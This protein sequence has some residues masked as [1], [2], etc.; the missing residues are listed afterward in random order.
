MTHI[1]VLKKEVLFYLNPKTN[2]NFVDCTFGE[3]GH[4]FAI[5]EKNIPEGKIL[6]IDRSPEIIKRV[7]K[8]CC[9]NWSFK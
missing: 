2:E 4:S 7:K 9:C 3:G 1:P 8:E 5:L 6:G